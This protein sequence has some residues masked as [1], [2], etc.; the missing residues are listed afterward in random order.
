M[1]ESSYPF[2]RADTVKMTEAIFN[3]ATAALPVILRMTA[4]SV[5]MTAV[6]GS[7]SAAPE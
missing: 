3:R 6:T 1:A 2:R 5:N 7:R 4:V